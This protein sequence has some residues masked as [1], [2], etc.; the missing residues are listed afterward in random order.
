MVPVIVLLIVAIGSSPRGR[1]TFTVGKPEV[2]GSMHQK[3]F[4][5]ANK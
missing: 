5:S 1:D 2:I 3:R 4:Q